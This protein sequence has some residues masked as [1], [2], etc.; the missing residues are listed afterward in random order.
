[1]EAEYKFKER[2][3]PKSNR[4]QNYDYSANGRYFITICTK[5]RENYFWE[6]VDWK[7]ILN[8]I[9]W[10]VENEILN[11]WIFRENV[12]IDEYMVMPNHVHFVLILDNNE[13]RDVLPKRLY[14]NENNNYN[15]NFSKISPKKWT[16]WNIMK[17]F[18]WFTTKTINKSQNEIFFAWQTNYYD[19]IIRDEDEL[20]R[21]RKYIDEN[22]EKWEQDK[23]NE[24]NLYM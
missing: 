12:I 19:R 6:I 3:N 9:W 8:E 7:M 23:D 24:E 15:N 21:I 5:D 22:P 13:C 11:I 17:L 1:M 2:Y 18:K 10:I 4:L 16:I 14:E 20:S